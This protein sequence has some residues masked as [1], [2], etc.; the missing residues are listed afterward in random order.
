MNHAGNK[1]AADG[2]LKVIT[3]RGDEVLSRARGAAAELGEWKPLSSLGAIFSLFFRG[4][5]GEGSV[6]S[7]IVSSK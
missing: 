4:G 5:W 1:T 3:N 2:V 6:L 7:L